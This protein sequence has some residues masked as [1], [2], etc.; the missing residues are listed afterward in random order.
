MCF[1]YKPLISYYIFRFMPKGMYLNA[2]ELGPVKL[3]SIMN[4][5]IRDKTKFYNFFKWHNHYSFHDPS[6]NND[7]DVVCGLCSFLNDD[8]RN[9]LIHFYENITSWW[10]EIYYWV[11]PPEISEFQIIRGI[12][13]D[14]INFVSSVPF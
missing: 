5:T 6:E 13:N 2:I 12:I 8:S 10:N 14:I 7:T 3:A 4:G 1:A 11:K 9:N